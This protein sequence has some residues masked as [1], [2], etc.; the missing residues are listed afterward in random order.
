MFK[1]KDDTLKKRRDFLNEVMKYVLELKS[2]NGFSNSQ[3]FVLNK[4]LAL[5]TVKFYDQKL[6]DMRTTHSAEDK[7]E[8]SRIAGMMADAILKFRPLVPINGN[9]V[10]EVEDI[11]YNVCN[12]FLAIYHGISICSAGYE[13]GPL[14]MG[15]FMSGKLFDRWLERFLYLLEQDYTMESLVMIFETL[16]VTV[17]PGTNT[18]NRK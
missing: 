18:N 6:K 14:L 16:C 5:K 4:S 3:T 13:N 17:F 8:D 9:D 1:D 15:E 10:I 11:E 12:E 7:V 2:K